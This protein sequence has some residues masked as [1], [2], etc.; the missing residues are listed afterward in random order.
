MIS[1]VVAA[2]RS[3]TSVLNNF[4]KMS[5]YSVPICRPC[6]GLSNVSKWCD[7]DSDDDRYDCLLG[8]ESGSPECHC[9]YDEQYG[10]NSGHDCGD[11][12]CGTDYNGKLCKCCQICRYVGTY[13]VDKK[14]MNMMKALALD[15]SQCSLC[16]R[17]KRSV[18][19]K[20]EKYVKEHKCRAVH[21]DISIIKLHSAI[22][23]KLDDP[24]D[25]PTGWIESWYVREQRA[26][27]NRVSFRSWWEPLI[28]EEEDALQCIAALF[29]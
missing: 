28:Q 22:L 3:L 12:R 13:P 20:F 15:M 4:T 26:K 7:I 16:S 17:C 25:E 18:Y 8:N 14:A 10:P 19:Y 2:G 1:A 5:L 6:L 27:K 11:Y 29:E 21:C 24:F 9:Y 23:P